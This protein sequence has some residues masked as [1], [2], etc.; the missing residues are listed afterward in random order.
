MTDQLAHPAVSVEIDDLRIV[1]RALTSEQLAEVRQGSASPATDAT[2]TASTPTSNWQG[3]PCT[4]HADCG[5]GNYCGLDNQCHPDAHAPMADAGQPTA[6]T[7]TG[8]GNTLEDMQARNRLDPATEAVIAERV[9]ENRPPDLTA[10]E[11]TTQQAG[12]LSP[13]AEDAIAERVAENRPPEIGY[14]SEEEAEEAQ[15]Q[16]EREAEQERERIAYETEQLPAPD[17]DAVLDLQTLDVKANLESEGDEFYL[18]RYP[19]RGQFGKGDRIYFFDYGKQVWPIRAGDDW[20]KQGEY[21][22]PRG[23]GRFSFAD[24]QPFEVYGYVAVL[25]EANRNTVEERTY[26]FGFGEFQNEVGVTQTVSTAFNRAVPNDINPPDLDDTS[27]RNIKEIWQRFETGVMEHFGDYSN[28]RSGLVKDILDVIAKPLERNR[29]DRLEGVM[30]GFYM[31][32][33]GGDRGQDCAGSPSGSLIP[34]VNEA[35]A[36][37]LGYTNVY[38]EHR[39]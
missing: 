30:W 8:G 34:K 3:A 17:I 7:G 19:L 16:R 2:Q 32:V 29:R 9:A 38:G 39:Q 24:L 37:N 27:C 23:A 4:A 21:D 12:R 35:F 20:A 33:P 26:A 31:N 28:T 6:T 10:T 13:E 18:V 15:R 36:F 25:M 1:G 14:A 5:N 11:E 22:I